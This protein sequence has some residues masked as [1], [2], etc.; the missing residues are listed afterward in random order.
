MSQRCVDGSREHHGV[1]IDADDRRNGMA[2]RER[3]GLFHRPLDIQEIE[4]EQRFGLG[5]LE[6]AGQLG[7]NGEID[8]RSAR[9]DHERF[10]AIRSGG[11]Q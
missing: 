5:C 6:G 1:V 10:G 7:S 11:Q 8:P 9:R 4:G 2:L 3:P